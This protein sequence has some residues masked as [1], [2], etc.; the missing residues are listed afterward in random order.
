MTPRCT[1]L[2]LFFDGELE[3]DRAAAFRDHLATCERCQRVLLGRMQE[4][5]AADTAAEDDIDSVAPDAAAPDPV[6][7]MADPGAE[8]AAAPRASRAME[9]APVPDEPEPIAEV[10]VPISDA[11]RA[12][13]RRRVLVYA[14]PI[15]AAAAA[16]PFIWLTGHDDAPLAF[17]CPIVPGSTR[18]RGAHVGD[19]LHPIVRGDRHRA[20]VVYFERQELRAACPGNAQCSE[21]D[22]TL[23]LR[24]RLNE[25]GTYTVVALGSDEVIPQPA[26]GET[27]EAFL[28]HCTG[29]HIARTTTSVD[30]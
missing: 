4:A 20:L 3:A 2:D 10:A 23:E 17:E 29:I 26:P 11:H 1:E 28:A 16:L 30:D 24:F 14:A 19:T 6:V 5:V 18:T 13:C 12:A 25:P 27:L 21:T 7:D 15:V 22:G 8:L 9:A